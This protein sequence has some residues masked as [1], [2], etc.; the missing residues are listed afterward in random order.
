VVPSAAALALLK[1]QHAP[2]GVT[3]T[4]PAGEQRVTIGWVPASLSVIE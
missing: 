1:L 2:S 3:R 4:F